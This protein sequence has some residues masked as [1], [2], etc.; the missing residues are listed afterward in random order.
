MDA[1]LFLRVAILPCM[2]RLQVGESMR[3]HIALAALLLCS[4]NITAAAG[5]VGTPQT[6]SA[7]LEM[8]EAVSIAL[9]QQPQLL[10][11]TAAVEALQ[12]SAVAAG[13]LPDPKLRF[14]I[15]NLPTDTYDFTQEPMTQA[16]I[17]LSQSIPGGSKLELSSQRTLREAKQSERLLA[18]IQRRIARDSR[19]SWLDVYYPAR[20]LDLVQKIREEYERQLEWSRITYTTGKLSQSDVLQLQTML[21]YVKDREDSLKLNLARAQAALGRWIG[22]EAMRMPA[23][24]LPLR[25]VPEIAEIQANL[26]SHPE[27]QALDSSLEVAQTDVDL[28]REAYKPDWNVDVSYGVR[29]DDRADFVS[30]IVSVDLP[31]FTEKRQDKRFAARVAS[32]EQTRQKIAD[33]QAALEADLKMAYANWRIATERIQRFEKGI[34]PL[35]EQQVES[36][37]AAYQ[38]ATQSF[39]RVLDARRALL[40]AQ[41]QMLQ[42]RVAR[43]R[44]EAELKYFME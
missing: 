43:A 26:P 8:D 30:M 23:E 44:A 14:G 4:A 27:L 42:Q 7:S 6:G 38:S 25:P 11:Q 18:S 21:E 24:N 2:K 34:L 28:A 22:S 41:L 36:A 10:G 20:A 3:N 19:I 9:S 5:T 31:L 33:R 39:A 12:E 1:P 29:G 35:A 32:A 17:G 40:E 13:Q 15:S 37:L 16:V